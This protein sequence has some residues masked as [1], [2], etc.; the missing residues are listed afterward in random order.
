MNFSSTKLPYLVQT[1]QLLQNLKRLGQ[2]VAL[3]SNNTSHENGRWSIISA[4]PIKTLS[5]YD[6]REFDTA[7][8]KINTQFLTLPAIKSNLPFTGGIIGHA[9][10]DLGI[11]SAKRPTDL[12]YKT[13]PL[14][15]CGLYTWA[16]IIDHTNKTTH[17]AYWSDVSMQPLKELMQIFDESINSIKPQKNFKLTTGFQSA[18]SKEDYHS[19][20]NKIH[21]YIKSGDTYQVNL[22]QHFTAKFIGEPLTAYDK[23]KLSAQVPFSC[24]FEGDNWCFASASP[25]LFLQYHNRIV[26]TKPIKGTLPVLKNKEENDKQKLRLTKSNKDLAENLMIVDLLRNDLSKHANN[27]KVEKLFSVESFPSVHHLVSTIKGKIDNEN[28]LKLFFDAFPGGSITGAPK[29]R[30]MEIIKELECF[31]RSFYCGS[32]FYFSC[33]DKFNSNILIR[34][35]LFENDEITCWAG[36]GIVHDSKWEDEHQESLDKISKLMQALN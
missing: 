9:A 23:L 13:Q 10:Y 5:L 4:A 34:S 32:S 25:E 7:L 12:K 1:T 21:E 16:F 8:D 2:L 19:K 33:N 20:I 27:I 30:A 22:A 11:P 29:I 15:T 3:E 6:I 28:I 35:F 36:G 26:T 24:Y 17:L 31:P 18:W 14:L